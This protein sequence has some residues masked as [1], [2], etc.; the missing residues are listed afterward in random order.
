MAANFRELLPLLVRNGVRFIVVG[1][2][3]VIA[4]GSARLTSDV[5]WS[6]HEM[7]PIFSDEQDRTPV[8]RIPQNSVSVPVF[9]LIIRAL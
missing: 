5:A 9:P 4:H 8:P 7:T 2:G 6:I 3:A 1:G